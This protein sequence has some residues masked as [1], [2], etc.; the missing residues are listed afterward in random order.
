MRDSVSYTKFEH[1]VVHKYR[2][3]LN[4]AESVEDVKKF[5]SYTMQELIHKAFAGQLSV[6]YEDV[7]LGVDA[8]EPLII[9]ESLRQQGE[10]ERAWSASDLPLIMTRLAKSAQNRFSHLQTH[11]EKTNA[12]IHRH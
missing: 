9:S 11:P 10:F 3:N 5:F 1:Q 7:Q 2:D 4:H 8:G 12:K 6:N